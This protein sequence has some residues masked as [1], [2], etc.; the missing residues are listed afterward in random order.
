LKQLFIIIFFSLSHSAH[1]NNITFIDESLNFEY[2]SSIAKIRWPDGN[3]IES[4]EAMGTLSTNDQNIKELDKEHQIN[5]NISNINLKTRLLFEVSAKIGIINI[6]SKEYRRN[7]KSPKLVIKTSLGDVILQ[8]KIDTYIVKNS[9]RSHGHKNIINIGGASIGLLLF[10]LPN[11]EN[12]EIQSAHIQLTATKRSY[13]DLTLQIRQLAFP[14]LKNKIQLGIAQNFLLDRNISASNEVY[15]AENF[16]NKKKWS[17]LGEF[18]KH[19]SSIYSKNVNMKY[20]EHKNLISHY[21]LESGY[22]I[23]ADFTTKKNLALNLDYYFKRQHG[24]EPEEAYFRY[25]LMLEPG[26]KVSG[27]GKLPGFGGTYDKA[28][29]GGRGNKGNEGWSAR[30]GFWAT[31]ELENSQWQGYMPIGQYIYEVGKDKYGQ[32]IPWGAERS[33]LESGKWYSIEQRMKLNTP[34]H[35]DGIL[36]VWINGYKV[37]SKKDVVLRNVSKLKIE[38]IWFN[39]FFGGKAKPKENF[40]MFIDNIVI[41]SSY[42]GPY[43]ITE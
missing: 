13:E 30:G 41:A 35:K 38:K 34:G 10:D 26:A 28:G 15:F 18:S 4:I 1:A 11:L 32:S 23:V 36:E 7:E 27:G 21:G 2:S 22:S 39:F 31:I 25:Y 8:P 33:T 40:K 29:W 20:I 6:H 19:D 9:W 17:R 12:V 3:I 14:K 43:Y 16:N 37:F 24:F 5:I 42:I